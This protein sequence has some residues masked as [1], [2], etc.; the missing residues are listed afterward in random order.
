MQ[1]EIEQAAYEYAKAVESGDEVVVGV[2]RFAEED[3]GEPEVFPIRPALADATRC[4]A[5]GAQGVAGPRRRRTPRIDD[6][7][8]A[9]RGTQ[10]LLDPHARGVAAPRDARRGVRCAPR[11]LRG[12]PPEPVTRPEHLEP[13]GLRSAAFKRAGRPLRRGGR[14]R[15]R[16]SQGRSSS[17][18]WRSAPSSTARSAAGLAAAAGELGL[19]IDR[20]QRVDRQQR[21]DRRDR[22]RHVAHVGRGP[23]VSPFCPGREDAAEWPRRWRGRAP[24][25]PRR[26]RNSEY[27]G[28]WGTISREAP[29]A[30]APASKH[31]HDS[32]LPGL[33]GCERLGAHI[34]LRHGQRGHDVR[35]GAPVGDDAVHLIVAGRVLAEEPDRDLGD[36]DRVGGIDAAVRGTPT[37]APPCR[38]SGRRSG[39]TARHGMRSSSRGDGCTMSAALTPSNPPRSQHEDLAAAAFLGGRAEDADGE[40]EV[41]RERRQAEAGADGGRRRSRCGRRHGRSRAGRR[42]RRRWRPSTVRCPPVARR[43]WA[44]RRLRARRRSRRLQAPRRTRLDACSSSKASSGWPWIIRDSPTNRSPAFA[45]L[46]RACCLAA[47]VV[48]TR[49]R[50]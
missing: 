23:S 32:R 30:S 7:R 35:G 20:W 42:T 37:R 6:V 25:S 3:A 8:A 36:G 49:V 47:S 21:M 16:R 4:A 31:R 41:V 13:G 17:T 46:V 29:V 15:P 38:C 12:V 2:N 18:P 24:P 48:V 33:Q 22:E 45:M 28:P 10:N 27:R 39:S 26:C 43:R 40:A 44:T 34:E 14:A 1:D 9:A 11:G 50:L 5:A 19:V